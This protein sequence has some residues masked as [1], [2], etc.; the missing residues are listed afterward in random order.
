[1]I[2]SSR[3]LYLSIP[4]HFSLSKINKTYLKIIKEL[5]SNYLI[6]AWFLWQPVSIHQQ[7]PY[8]DK[9]VWASPGDF[10][11]LF[12]NAE[13]SETRKCFYLKIKES[14]SELPLPF[15]KKITEAEVSQ[16][17][18]MDP[19]NKLQRQKEGQWRQVGGQPG[20]SCHYMM[21]LA[22]KSARNLQSFREIKQRYT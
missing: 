9:V 3:C 16:L 17:G 12:I 1:M 22:C 13:D 19:G 5:S 6:N 2:L 20:T 14:R 4:L 21:F 7:S 11:C 10:E 8:Q 18:C 15:R